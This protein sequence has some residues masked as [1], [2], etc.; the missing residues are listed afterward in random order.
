MAQVDLRE[1]PAIEPAGASGTHF[2]LFARDFLS[3]MGFTVIEGPDRGQDDGRDLLV[4]EQLDGRITRTNKRWLV[5][6]K[7]QAHSGKAVGRSAEPDIEGRLAQF[8]ATGFL[9]FYST[10]P[11]APLARRLRS[12]AGGASVFIYDRGRIADA[13]TSVPALDKVF[14][15][16][17]PESYG[18]AIAPRLQLSTELGVAFPNDISVHLKLAEIL[19]STEKGVLRLSDPELEDIV[20]ACFLADALRRGKFEILKEFTSFRPLVWRYLTQLVAGGKVD[21]GRLAREITAGQRTSYLRLLIAISGCVGGTET[22]EPICRCIME[23]GRHHA[24]EVALWPVPVTP[25][26]DTVK[27]ALANLPSPT[28]TTLQKYREIAKIG[29]HWKEKEVFEW[30]AKQIGKRLVSRPANPRLQ[31]PADAAR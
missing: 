23:A 7:H 9:G 11:S 29:K 10:E 18:A 25:F 1:I 13:L 3:G 26:Y 6:V 22:A 19:D 30:A 27:E 20:A 21:S 4:E 8:G 17:L 2:E 12:V 16:H 5:S 14:Q 28:I 31:R 15:R 24:Y